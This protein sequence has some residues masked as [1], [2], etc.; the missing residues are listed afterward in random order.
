MSELSELSE[1]AQNYLKVIWG[2]K[3]WSDAPV[4]ASMIAAR[5]GVKLS[6]ASGAVGKLADQDLVAHAPY[7]AVTLT[8]QGRQYALA[9][10]RRHRLI[11]TFLVEVLGY[12]W[13]QVH[14]E[15]EHLEH[16]VSDFLVERLDAHLGRPTRDP[17]GDPIP[18]ADGSVPVPTAQ[19]LA[20]VEPGRQVVVERISDADPELLR[21]FSE[22]G[23]VVGTRLDVSAGPPF[24]EALHVRTESGA[25]PV[26]LGAAAAASVWVSLPD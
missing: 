10:V 22:Q 23:I 6:T 3:E 17:H 20:G 13:D 15:A 9:M 1:S 21:Y 16:A 25:A 8:D 19:L 24:S 7:S 18:D 5:A 14:D 26:S 11:E 12:R 2:L 4:T